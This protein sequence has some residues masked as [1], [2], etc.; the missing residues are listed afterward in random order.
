MPLNRSINIGI[1]CIIIIITTTAFSVITLVQKSHNDYLYSNL[2]G[3][4]SIIKVLIIDNI[5]ILSEA[6]NLDKAEQ[7]GSPVLTGV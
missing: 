2:E 6:Y 5:K 4:H 1:C 3:Y 7:D